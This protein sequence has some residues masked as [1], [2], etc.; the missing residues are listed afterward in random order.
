MLLHSCLAY[1]E[2]WQ[3]EGLTERFYPESC[4]HNLHQKGGRGAWQSRQGT[5]TSSWKTGK[6]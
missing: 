2:R 4:L 3:P 1:Q 6:S 5:A